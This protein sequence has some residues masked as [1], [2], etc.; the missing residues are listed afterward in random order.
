MCFSAEADVLAG[1][2]VTAVGVDALRQV[3]HP[4]ERLL[5]ALPVL[6]GA[7]LLVEAAVWWGLTGDIAASTGRLAMWIYLV[8]AVGVLPV[9]VPL[10][11][12]AVEPD[13]GRRRAMAWLGVTGALLA[14]VYLI[15]LVQGP[16]TVRIEGYHLAY[17]LN[18]DYGGLLAAVYALVACAPPLLSSHRRVARFGVANLLA[19]LVLA[20]VESSALTSLWCA[21]AAITSVAIAAHLRRERRPPEVRVNVT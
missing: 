16:I 13:A 5:G 1:V 12:R 19:V 9:L 11:V 8:F 17:Q 7:H 15:G 14:G 2:V 3:H 21:W 4:G 6:L 10:A 18:M 20:W